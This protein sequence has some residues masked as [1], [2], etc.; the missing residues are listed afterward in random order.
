MNKTLSGTI[1][2]FTLYLGAVVPVSATADPGRASEV[3][4]DVVHV[5][6]TNQVYCH[7]PIMSEKEREEVK[8]TLEKLPEVERVSINEK[9]VSVVINTTSHTAPLVVAQVIAHYFGK[10]AEL[11]EAVIR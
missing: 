1:L 4:M 10:K 6:S 2:F 7:L 8:Q 5:Q 11:V 3:T 9:K